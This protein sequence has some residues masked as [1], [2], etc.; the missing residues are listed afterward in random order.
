MKKPTSNLPNSSAFAGFMNNIT[1]KFGVA[2]AET[3]LSVDEAL[4]GILVEGGVK[5]TVLPLKWGKI[6]IEAEDAPAAQ[7]VRYLMTQIEDLLRERNVDAAVIVRV[8][9]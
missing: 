3:Q 4:E 7:Q 9:R 6:I 1:A 8:K 5:A 2:D